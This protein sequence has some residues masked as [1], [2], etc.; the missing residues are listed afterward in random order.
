MQPKSV[1]SEELSSDEVR[2]RIMRAV[3]REN[4]SPK[5]RVRRFLHRHGLRFRLHNNTLPRTPDLVLP[6]RS[7]VIYVQGCFWH[8]HNGC[9]KTTVPKTLQTFW[10][11][12]FSK[13]ANRDANN[14]HVLRTLGWKVVVAWEDKT[15]SEEDLSRALASLLIGSEVDG[16]RY[17]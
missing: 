7:T 14:E 15:Y 10:N 3:P 5:R 8:R 17:E 9:R 1:G 4:A 6:Q 16:R 12:K 2:S 13:N 11:E